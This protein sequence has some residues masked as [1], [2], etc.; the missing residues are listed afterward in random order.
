M[1]ALL[2]DF[3]PRCRVDEKRGVDGW[4]RPKNPSK[5]PR[6][7]PLEGAALF[8]RTTGNFGGRK[9]GDGEQR[10]YP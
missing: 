1:G 6:D 3:A 2:V 8:C 10:M 5:L 9:T 4:R 7:H